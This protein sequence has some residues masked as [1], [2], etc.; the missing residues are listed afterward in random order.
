VFPSRK[1]NFQEILP[2]L[3]EKMKQIYVLKKLTYCIS[4][5]SSFDL[6]MSKGVHDIFALVTNFLG[7][8]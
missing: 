3:V 5:T 8:D 2:N 7:C 6:W 1:Q 4:A